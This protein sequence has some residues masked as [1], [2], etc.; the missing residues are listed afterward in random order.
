MWTSYRISD[1][2]EAIDHCFSIVN[3]TDDH[4]CAE[5]K[6]EHMRLCGWLG[7][8][9]SRVEAEQALKERE[10]ELEARQNE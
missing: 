1:L 10:K 3:S 6:A 4:I 5:C 7:E 8:L 9:K 2:D